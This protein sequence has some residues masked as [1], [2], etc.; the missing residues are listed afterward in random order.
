MLYVK[1]LPKNSEIN[2]KTMRNQTLCHTTYLKYLNYC[3]NLP[4]PNNEAHAL[5][6][7]L[8]LV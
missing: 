5:L 3:K 2:V 7:I 4:K 8:K 6:K 1:R